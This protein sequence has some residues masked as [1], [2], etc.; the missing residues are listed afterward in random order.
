MRTFLIWALAA[1][2]P[3]AASAA[4][5]TVS[6]AASLTNAFRELAQAFEA[7]H[8][9]DKVLLNFAASDPLV[10]QIAKG[11]PVDVFASADQE[12]MDKAEALKLLAPGTRRDFVTN[13]VVVVVPTASALK[14][15]TLADLDVPAVQR[16][17]TG[18]PASVPIGRYAKDAL[19]KAGVWARLEPK[20]V[21]GGSVRQSLDYVARGE[22]DAG[23]VYATDVM[24]QK[25]K[26]RAVLTVPTTAP[27]RYPVAVLAGAPQPQLARSFAQYVLSPAGQAILG[28]HGFTRP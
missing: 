18:N 6:A 13:T 12:A 27:V 26:V 16:L 25:D 5:V 7:A 4:D 17:T 23:F 21:Y 10:Q 3:A 11:A 28:K 24:A 19:T 14:P 2:L 20:F 9:G 22:V 8:P 1:A 15:A